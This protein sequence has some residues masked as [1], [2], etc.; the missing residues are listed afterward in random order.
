M[1]DGQVQQQMQ[2]LDAPIR[3]PNTKL[4]KAQNS[5]LMSDNQETQAHNTS[6]QSPNSPS[7]RKVYIAAPQKDLIN[8]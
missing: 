7:N 1:I 5:L 6:S 8:I 2:L 3:K 4:Y